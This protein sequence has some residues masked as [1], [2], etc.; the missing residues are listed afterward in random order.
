MLDLCIL[1]LMV[2]FLQVRFL[3][4]LAYSFAKTAD[5]GA[6]RGILSRRV[7]LFSHRVQF[8]SQSRLLL[9]STLSY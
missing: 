2:R 9:V 4:E 5:I 1:Q 7:V 8:H 6:N 3:G